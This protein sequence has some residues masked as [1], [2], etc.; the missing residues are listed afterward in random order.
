MNVARAL[1]TTPWLLVADEIVSGLD[2]LVQAQVLSLLLDL[3][4]SHG[5]SVLFIS[6]NLAVV[7]YLCERVVMMR[8]GE[9]VEAGMTEAVFAAPAHLYTRGLLDAVPYSHRAAEWPP[10]TILEDA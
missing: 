7:R 8:G 9:I 3:R 2:V 4:A 1:C 5:L 10:A 6:Q